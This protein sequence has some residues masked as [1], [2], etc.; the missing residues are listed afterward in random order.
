MIEVLIVLILAAL[1]TGL[2]G[3]FLLLKKE[4][5]TTDALSHTIILGIVIAFFFTEDTR[6]PLLILGASLVGVVTVMLIQWIQKIKLIKGDAAIGIVF[7]SLFALA[8][9]LISRFLDHIHL[10]IDIVLV[11]EVLFAPFNRMEFFGLDLPVAVVQLSIL[12]VVNLLFIILFYNPL[13][14][15]TFDGTFAVTAG[16]YSLVL[17]YTLMVLVSL[18]AVTAFDA[19]GAILVIS[20]FVAPAV[21]AYLLVNKLSHMLFVTIGIALFNSVVGFFIGYYTDV[22]ISGMTASVAFVTFTIVFLFNKNG[23]ITARIQ[24]A[25][26]KRDLL[27]LMVVLYVRDNDSVSRDAI[28]QYFNREAREIETAIK[29]VLDAGWVE[30]AEAQFV[31]TDKGLAYIEKTSHHYGLSL[32]GDTA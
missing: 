25:Q 2:L 27:Q 10:D 22:T 1:A 15:T 8:I 20:F 26:S 5:M 3:V 19:V 28:H 17:Y 4:V 13:K 24:L 30:Q 11:G 12:V 32:R 14:I 7:T 18:T 6:S 21:T 23:Y 16:I 29:K 9:I 31:L